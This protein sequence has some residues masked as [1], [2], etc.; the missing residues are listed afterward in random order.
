MEIIEF[1]YVSIIDEIKL[2]WTISNISVDL[3]LLSV[4][5]I[6]V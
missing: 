2:I 1:F 4:L 6:L 3:I 5:Y